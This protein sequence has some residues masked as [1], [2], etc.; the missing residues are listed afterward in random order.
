MSKI[1]NTDSCGIFECSY[2]TKEAH[3]AIVVLYIIATIINFCGNALVWKTVMRNTSLR[4]PTNYLLL[5]ISLAD[6]ISGI[7]IYPY[8][9][10]LDT[11]KASSEP[12]TQAGLCMVAEGQ[13]IF[14]IASLVSLAILC[15]LSYNRF[16]AVKY[17][18][19]ANLRM[20]RKS[21]II[22]SILAWVIVTIMMMPNMVTYKYESELRTCTHDWG[23]INANAYRLCVLLAGTVIP[24]V[25]LLM[26]YLA[27]IL[28]ARRNAQLR[29]N[30]NA[31]SNTDTKLKKAEKMIGVLILVYVICWLPI[32]TYW[33]IESFTSY[34][35][36]TVEGQRKLNRW[37]RVTVFFCTLNAT[38]NPIVC[39]YGISGINRSLRRSFSS[40]RISTF[41]ES[42]SVNE[43]SRKGQ[44]KAQ[45]TVTVR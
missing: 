17:P 42:I 27:V 23:Q 8:L 6:V 2:F 14:F 7:S 9:F 33:T 15:G 35:P 10:I 4:T 38:I 40:T 26:S 31:T 1:S 32:S 39:I 12:R 36:K 3:I 13:G 20:N 11:G 16:M 43:L 18:L 37:V 25:F 5:N 45:D 29:Q 28:R 34:F 21:S 30:R 44:G 41:T 24:T 22:F 19:K